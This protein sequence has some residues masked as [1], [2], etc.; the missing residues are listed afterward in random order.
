MIYDTENATVV[1]FADDT[2]FQT[3]N[4][5]ANMATIELQKQLDLE[6]EWFHKWKIYINE[7]K[8][9]MYFLAEQNIIDPSQSIKRENNQLVHIGEISL[10]DNYRPP[11][12]LRQLR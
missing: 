12:Q 6:S 2:L 9:S 7:E 4:Y 11:S 10:S 5:N 3:K 8:Q 1:L